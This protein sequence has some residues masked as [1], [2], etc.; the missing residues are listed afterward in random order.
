MILLLACLT[1]PSEEKNTPITPEPHD[2]ATDAPTD[3]PTDSPA[4]SPHDSPPPD[5]QESQPS[6]SDTSPPD[7][8]FW[9]SALYPEDWTPDF[10]ATD[11]HFLH[12][13]SYAGYHRSEIPLPAV[14][15]GAS[16]DVLSFGADISGQ[17]DST[18]AIQAAVDAAASA[19][20]GVVSLPAG[21]FRIDGT[22]VIQ[23]SNIVLQGA[24]SGSTFVY[25]TQTSSD[26]NAHLRF[27]GN[28]VQSTEYMLSQDG[29]SRSAVVY[30]AD[31]SGLAVGDEVSVGQLISDDFVADH[32]MTGTWVEFNGLWRAFFRRTVVAVDTTVSPN[33]VTLDIPLRYE[34]LI[35]DSASL[36]KESGYLTECG[37]EDLALSDAGNYLDAWTHNQVD[38]VSFSEVSDC[39]V[40]RV[41]SWSS[42]LSDP[43]G[44]H[45]FNN[46]LLVS[47]SKRVTVT[48]TDLGYAENRGSGG[49]GYLFEVRRSNEILTQDSVGTAGRHNFIQNWDFGTSG[50]VWLRTESYDGRSMLADWDSVGYPS[51]SEFHHSLAMANLIDQSVAADGWQGVNRQ[52]ESSGAGHSVTESVFW[53]ISGG[54]Y[55][56]SLQFGDGYVIGTT[57]MEVHTD[58]NE[59]DWNNSGEGTEPA[60]WLEGEDIGSTLEPVSLF[61][62]QRFKRLGF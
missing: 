3:S 31:A 55:L 52:A 21:T 4:D 46:G 41:A 17:S 32:G 9:R 13:F 57:D 15:P 37:I 36:R 27:Q 51:Y 30:V 25:F 6:D 54:G 42:P 58:P 50:C 40:R 19:G 45:I 2:S 38:M 43:A 24:G 8:G 10:T 12:D 14:P 47:D 26:Y 39:W 44:Y 20:G 1:P 16:F 33:A 7:P 35:R 56:R 61:E 62:D 60:D 23:D 5:S 59:W 48:D 34:M 28:L 29:A 22:V 18:A 49:N 53:N 11:G